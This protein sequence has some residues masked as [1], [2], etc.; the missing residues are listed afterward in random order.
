MHLNRYITRTGLVV[1]AMLVLAPAAQAGPRHPLTPD[2]WA[3]RPAPN[4]GAVHTAAVQMLPDDLPNHPHPTPMTEAPVVVVR[5]TSGGGFAWG[6][7]AI[8]AAAM[9][10]LTFVAGAATAGVRSRRRTLAA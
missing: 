10:G 9:L 8:G 1:A 2:N 5:S 3:V 4:A 7:A 6:D